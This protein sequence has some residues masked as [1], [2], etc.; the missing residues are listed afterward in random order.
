MGYTFLNYADINHRTAS[1][2]LSIQLSIQGLSMEDLEFISD[3]ELNQEADIYQDIE[4][5]SYLD[6]PRHDQAYYLNKGD[7]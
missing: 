6:D 2:H 7:Y 3:Y 5:D 1:I 4:T